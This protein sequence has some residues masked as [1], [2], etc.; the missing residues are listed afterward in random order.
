MNPP[1]L[2]LFVYG[3]LKRGFDNHFRLCRGLRA[4]EVAEME[5]DLYRLPSGY[6]V[7][8]LPATRWLARATGRS[9]ADLE[10]QA[11][12][13]EKVVPTEIAR[14]AMSRG[15]ERRVSGELLTFSN[16]AD[17]LAGI[18]A[19][20]QFRAGHKSPYERVLIPVYSRTRQSR[21]AAWTYVAGDLA[22]RGRLI[23]TGR[24]DG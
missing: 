19:L 15:G 5:G 18:D 22:P 4:V 3:S 23:P 13:D 17:R 6:P 12:F 8:R 7:L 20:E 1:L 9:G 14:T 21:V 16:A 2:R 10:I 11:G 24:W